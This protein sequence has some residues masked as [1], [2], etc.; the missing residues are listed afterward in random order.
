M[1]TRGMY[2]PTRPTGKRTQL[3]LAST[4]NL[5]LPEES[6]VPLCYFWKVREEGGKKRKE[7]PSAAS[8]P[9][10]QRGETR[11]PK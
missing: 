3:F 4:P 2:V 11:D 9:S 7:A 6:Q 8:H 5:T 1:A 10:S